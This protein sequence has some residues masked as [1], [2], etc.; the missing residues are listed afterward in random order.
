MIMIRK[1]LP[2]LAVSMVLLSGSCL[3]VFNSREFEYAAETGAI[4][5]IQTMSAE[6]TQQGKDDALILAAKNGHY[7]VAKFLVQ[8]GANISVLDD[9]LRMQVLLLVALDQADTERVKTIMQPLSRDA[10]NKL[11]ILAAK[12]GLLPVVQFLLG[13]EINGHQL[14]K[15]KIANIHAD[16]DEALLAAAIN[17]HYEVAKFL[18]QQGAFLSMF[19][20][21][22]NE[23]VSNRIF[24]DLFAINNQLVAALNRFDTAQVQ[25]IMTKLSIG[26]KNQLLALAAAS[27]QLA[28]VQFLLGIEVN[29]NQLPIGQIAD[30]HADNDFALRAAFRHPAFIPWIRSLDRYDVAKFLVQQGASISVLP[31]V[32]RIRVSLLVALDQADTQRV[33]AIM[34]PLV[35]DVTTK[36]KLL[37]WAAEKGFLPVVQFLLGMKVNGHQ[38]PEAQIANIHVDDDALWGAI[39]EGHLAVASFL[40][41]QGATFSVL[42]DAVKTGHLKR[43]DREKI[44]KNI[45]D[46]LVAALNRNDTAQTQAITT[47]MSI[48]AKNELLLW[49]AKNNQKAVA[50]FL[51]QQD[52][53]LSILS[54]LSYQFKQSIMASIYTQL[55]QAL[56]QGDAVKIQTITAARGVRDQLLILAAENGQLAVVQFLLGMKINGQQ[57]PSFNK[58]ADI[59]AN[60]D[61][62]LLAAARNGHYEVA[63]FLVQQGADLSILPDQLRE[64]IMALIYTPLIQALE[65]GDAVKIQTITATRGMRDQ[66][67]SLAA[68]EGNLEIVQFLLGMNV[69]GHQLPADKIANIY[70]DNDKALLQAVWK[71]YL[72]IVQFLLGVNINGHQLP[73]YKIA[74]IHA[75]NDA[76]LR[77][78]AEN[79]HLAI[80]QFLL[81][82]SIDGHQLPET[83]IADIHADNDK[84]LR[85]AVWKGYLKIVQ[86]LLGVNINGHQLPVDKI[87]NI[88]AENDAVFKLAH[89]YDHLAIQKFLEGWLKV[90]QLAPFFATMDISAERQPQVA[91]EF[92]KYRLPA[93]ATAPKETIILLLK[94]IN[95]QLEP[96]SA[97]SVTNVFFAGPHS[98]LTSEG[99]ETIKRYSQVTRK[100][101][102]NPATKQP[103]LMR[104][105]VKSID[106]LLRALYGDKY[107]IDFIPVQDISSQGIEINRAELERIAQ[108]LAQQYA[109]A[110]PTEQEKAER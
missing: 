43:E 35:W 31:P 21:V 7:E 92:A 29:R 107:D 106:A 23:R 18:V 109:V 91:E 67:L 81:G 110:L 4:A 56:E 84:A 33:K 66:L 99:W 100:P 19:Y 50:Q 27:G 79:G 12:N 52:A 37:I 20:N 16:N 26:T 64:S 58:T 6:A 34:Q 14:P 53:D 36:S 22:S 95:S 76:A 49:A 1:L 65:Q 24:E 17:G 25:A 39:R 70:A 94:A 71:G 3:A 2:M 32:D 75:K 98:W 59:H 11:L 45:A 78:A 97:Q 15:D 5:R 73:A 42:N 77:L 46:Q 60:N 63:Q 13:M 10:T 8:Q 38:L 108:H 28:V 47:K 51:V 103:L 85:G 68:E 88:H 96:A 105:P 102:E 62:A 89:D 82:M 80:V 30:I 40:I 55:I 57:L 54:D 41:E 101:L 90:A 83:R 87:A 72:K 86:F 104:L 48:D 9:V 93:A 69:N 74:N 61:A 44:V